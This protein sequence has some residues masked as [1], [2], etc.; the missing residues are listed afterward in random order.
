V[1]WA[2]APVA[3]PADSSAHSAAD[4]RSPFIFPPS[5]LGHQ[6]FGAIV[7]EDHGDRVDDPLILV[8]LAVFDHLVL[9]DAAL[10]EVGVVLVRKTVVPAAVPT[11]EGVCVFLIGVGELAAG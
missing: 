6:P 5:L 11:R 9:D 7:L 1:C 4:R 10:L 2:R 3:R 8:R